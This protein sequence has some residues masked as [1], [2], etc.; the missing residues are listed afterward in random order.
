[1]ADIF[2]IYKRLSSLAVFSGVRKTPL[3]SLFLNYCEQ[4]SGSAKKEL[5]YGELINEIYG[6]GANLTD[7]VRRIAFEDENVYV[8]AIGKKEEVNPHVAR[9]VEYELNALSEFAALTPDDF[10]TD[11]G[12]KNYVHSFDS[13]KADLCAE[14]MSRI[15]NIEKYGYGI[16]AAHGMFSVGDDGTI[17]PI[18]SADRTT[19][20]N[21]VGY[22]EERQKVIHNTEMFLSDKP[23]ANILLYGD[24]GTGKSSTVKAVAN[25]FFDMGLRLI[26]IRKNQLLLLPK[27]MGEISNNP[28]HFIIFIDDLS[29]NKNDDSFS[30][31]K[32]TLEGSASARAKNAV[33]YATSNRRH[34]VRETFSDREG[35][36]LHRND[37]IQENLSLSARF[38]LSILFAKPEK[39]LYLDIVHELAERNGIDIP[40]DEL[41]RDAEAF[42]LKRGHRSARAAEQFIDSLL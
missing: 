11:M 19:L 30:M 18:A 27:I 20:D 8:R 24:A 31:L 28:L 16:F 17:I 26:E 5:A 10:A 38:G 4:E 1:M 21:F 41:D 35:D 33:I 15:S 6:G 39:K 32:A 7:C 12:H 25:H 40:M 14:Y 3:F 9:A 13:E 29:F 37:T 23:A 42:A 34:I 22:E 2:T 36:E